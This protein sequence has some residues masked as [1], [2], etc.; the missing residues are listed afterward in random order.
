MNTVLI[1]CGQVAAGYAIDP[2]YAKFYRYSTHA[3]V[4]HAHPDF[5]WVAAV[6]PAER[7][8]AAIS[9]QWTRI[10]TVPSVKDLPSE[11]AQFDVAVIATPPKLRMEVIRGL[12]GS[13]RAILV[14]KPLAL[15][16]KECQSI[17]RHCRKQ[18]IRLQVNLWRRADELH[19]R[20]AAGELKKYIGTLSGIGIV[21]GGGLRNTGTHLMDF[22]EMMGGSIDTVTALPD[23]ADPDAKDPSYSAVIAL[24]SGMTATLLA[25][26]A[27]RYRALSIDM[28]GTTGLLR[29][30]QEGLRSEVWPV[31]GH[32][33]LSGAREIACDEPGKVLRPTVGEAFYHLYTNLAEAGR[34]GEALWASGETACRAGQVVAAIEQSAK[35]GGKLVRL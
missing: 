30:S 2:Q 12:P 16:V 24:K 26:D 5:N 29:I 35:A 4:L 31:R 14:E 13:V 3:Q 7:A 17:I 33:A 1:G 25:V 20:L 19:R 11:I 22:L 8:R 32:R 15:T 6:D 18:S 34:G 10:V 27:A 9:K 21:Y 28:W 23:P